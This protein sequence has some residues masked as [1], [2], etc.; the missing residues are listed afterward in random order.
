MLK[1]IVSFV[2]S[3]SILAGSC[4]FGASAGA[5]QAGRIDLTTARKIAVF[6]LATLEPV[7]VNNGKDPVKLGSD[8]K[9]TGTHPLYNGT[10]EIAFYNFDFQSTAHNNLK[11]YITVSLN[12]DLPYVMEH[13]F[14]ACPYS[15]NGVE[16][17]YYISPMIYFTKAADGTYRNQNGKTV[18]YADVKDCFNDYK[19]FRTS[20]YSKNSTLINEVTNDNAKLMS[21][22]VKIESKNFFS[23]LYHEIYQYFLNLLDYFVGTFEHTGDISQINTAVE[24]IIKKDAGDGYKVTCSYTVDKRYMV[25]QY[26]YYYQEDIGSGICGKASSMMALAFYRDGKGYT[27]LPD[28]KTMYAELSAIYDD[29]TDK[30]SIFFENKYINNELGISQS[31]EMLG[32]LD[33]GLAYYLYSKGYKDAARNVIDNACFDITMVPDAVCYSLMQGLRAAMSGWIAEKTNGEL[34]FTTSVKAKASDVIINSLKKEEPAVIGCLTAIGCDMYSNHYVAAVGYYKA[35][36]PYQLNGKTLF[37]LSKEYVE[38]YDT[39]WYESS[40]I[41]WSV[42]KSTAMYSS[43]SLADLI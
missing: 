16:K 36:Y 42:F 1:K 6:Y 11:G 9:L 15:G 27:A 17:T 5:A 33:M 38:V 28:D 7:S 26:Q 34:S 35:D 31:Y 30:F 40:V 32:T 10:D 14:S 3:V 43:T 21:A 19:A 2:L 29:I 22:V 4:S 12:T 13:R 8:F 20:L 23:I 41:D 25:P 39:W 37:T 24:D 18:K